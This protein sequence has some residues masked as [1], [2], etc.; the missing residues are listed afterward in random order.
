MTR[1]AREI[2]D[3]LPHVE[4]DPD[5]LEAFAAD[6]ERPRNVLYRVQ[7][8]REDRFERIGGGGVDLEELERAPERYRSG[9]LGRLPH[10]TLLVHGAY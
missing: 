5:E 9:I 6:P 3:R 4:L 2:F 10:L 7:F 8:D 1:G